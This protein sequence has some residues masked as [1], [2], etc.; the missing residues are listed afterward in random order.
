MTCNTNDW[1]RDGI[2]ADIDKKGLKSALIP[3]ILDLR[4]SNKEW[5]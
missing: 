4:G 2:G 5:Y 1:I 3:L